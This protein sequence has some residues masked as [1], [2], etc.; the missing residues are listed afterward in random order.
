MEESKNK[1][2]GYVTAGIVAVFIIIFAIMFCGPGSNGSGSSSSQNQST[3]I[4]LKASVRF[5]GTQFVILNNDS[6]DWTN[7][8]LEINSQGLRSGYI[9]RASRLSAGAEY[10]VGAMQFAK[11]DGEKFNP[12]THK[13]TNF[14]ISCTAQGGKSGFYFGEWN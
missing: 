13:P 3:S 7:I 10:T 14:S 12:F 9:L 4:D 5:T 6:F 1:V 2:V 11:K 8:K